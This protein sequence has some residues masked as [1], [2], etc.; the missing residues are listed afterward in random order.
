MLGSDGGLARFRLVVEPWLAFAGHTHDSQVFQSMSVRGI[1]DAVF[2][3]YIGRGR[4]APAW[5][6]EL[7]D[8]AVYAERSLCIQYQ[9]SDLA[10][11]E[12]LL[13]EEGIVCWF[14]HEGAPGDAALGTHTLVLGDHAAAFAANAQRVV[15]FTQSGA[16]MAE[17]SLVR[18][19]G[20][21]AVQTSAVRLSSPD[22][23]AASAVSI[24][25]DSA[26]AGSPSGLE[27]QDVPGQYAYEDRAQGERLALRRQQALDA[28]AAVTRAGHGARRRWARRSR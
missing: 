8:A 6:W 15:R 27:L 12:R 20:G 2:G 25:Q 4:L 21:R 28:R 11:V 18:F 1:V 3:S 10:F 17:D 16:S 23:R 24:S 5:R 7:A 14:E 26:D 9:E 22:Y 19:T 13:S